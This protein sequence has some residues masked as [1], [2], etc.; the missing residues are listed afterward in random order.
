APNPPAS[1]RLPLFSW[2]GAVRF[3]SLPPVNGF[4][5]WEGAWIAPLEALP[6]G[7]WSRPWILASL[8]LLLSLVFL[9]GLF[10]VLRAAA[11]ERAALQVRSEFLTS[12][13]H[14]LRTPL[15]SIRMFAEML[16]EDRVPSE[17]KRKEYYRLLS[18]ETGRLSAL[19]ENVLDLGRM[20]RGE[21]A[22]DMRP[23]DFARLARN[24]L[25]LFSP[26]A[27]REGLEVKT[28]L[29]GPAP[30]LGD[31]NALEQALEN[32]L[33]NAR[34]YAG[35]GRILQVELAAARDGGDIRLR[36]RDR[37]PGIPPEERERIFEPFTRG[38]AQEDGSIPGVG[39]GLYLSRRILRAHGGDLLCLDPEDGEGG[40]CFE[41][42]LP[43]KKE[44]EE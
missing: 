42:R 30:V 36:V 10:L 16:A 41:I 3:G 15:A 19:V 14:E 17:E 7:I 9:L 33:E 26:L 1:R 24:V 11:R 35:P 20:E 12:V 27:R 44:E 39:L 8:L 25:D 43:E 37:G 32:L 13:T 29:E 18:G 23:L 5:L 6:G 40:A 31:R 34:K 2:S 28:R 21:R 38:K 4:P 22:Y